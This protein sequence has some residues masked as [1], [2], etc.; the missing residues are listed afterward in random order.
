MGGP[1]YIVMA[2]WS[3]VI[4]LSPDSPLSYRYGQIVP[5]YRV[6]IDSSLLYN[7]DLV[8]DSGAQCRSGVRAARAYAFFL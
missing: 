4:E 8:A 5:C 3:P 6:M 1:C 7:Y 2:R